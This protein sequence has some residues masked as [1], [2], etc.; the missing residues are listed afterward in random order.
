MIRNAL[1]QYVS[2]APPDSGSDSSQKGFAALIP[3]VR[4]AKITVSLPKTVW[5][6]PSTLGALRFYGFRRW[7]ASSI[8]YRR[9]ILVEQ[10]VL[11]DFPSH[12]PG[13]DGK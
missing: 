5:L 1:A 8:S 3:A 9:T 12:L 10:A 13:D 4:P 6:V 2:G 7:L 11:D